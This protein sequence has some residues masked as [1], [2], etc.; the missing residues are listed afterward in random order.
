MFFFLLDTLFW[1]TFV[2]NI[3]WQLN[4][5][6]HVRIRIGIRI[7]EDVLCLDVNQKGGRDQVPQPGDNKLSKIEAKNSSKSYNI[8]FT[9]F[10]INFANKLNLLSRLFI[11]LPFS[12]FCV[13]KFP[14]WHLDPQYGRSSGSGSEWR[15]MRIQ[16]LDS[17][18]NKWESPTLNKS[19]NSLTLTLNYFSLIF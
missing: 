8:F 15:Q 19:F 13:L 16:D 7:Q 2:Q 6:S 17:N 12:N 5:D 14:P 9:Y 11:I 1:H 18:Y 4:N 10:G 3:C